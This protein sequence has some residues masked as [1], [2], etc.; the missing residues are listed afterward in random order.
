MDECI[1]EVCKALVIHRSAGQAMGLLAI[2]IEADDRVHT[3]VKAARILFSLLEGEAVS[4]AFVWS[5]V[6]Y[7]ED[8]SDIE[9]AAP[10]SIE[11]LSNCRVKLLLDALSGE[12]NR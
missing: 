5:F 9:V 8:V 6:D 12:D 7:Y 10:M 2:E 3:L 4:N 11:T 1:E